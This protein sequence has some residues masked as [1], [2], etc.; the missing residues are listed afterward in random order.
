MALEPEER[1]TPTDFRDRLTKSESGETRGLDSVLGNALGDE[2]FWARELLA[3]EV[4]DPTG[5]RPDA[6]RFFDFFAKGAFFNLMFGFGKGLELR[7]T[8][9]TTPPVI[10]S[11]FRSVNGMAKKC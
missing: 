4:R 11:C 6:R 9:R 10:A 2:V 5:F 1:G 7:S 8:V 3:A